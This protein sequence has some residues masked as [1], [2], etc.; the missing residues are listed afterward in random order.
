MLA[1]VA[2]IAG[3]FVVRQTAARWINDYTE[4]T[5]TQVEQVEYS[6]SQMDALNSRLAV[7]KQALDKGQTSVELV[8]TAEDLNALIAKEREWRGKLFVRID[9]DIVRGDVSIPLKDLG[10]FK[11]NGRYLNGTATF[12]LALAD[13][14][15]Q[16]RLREVQVR[17]KPLPAMVLAELKKENL[18]K[19][20]QQDP[21]A[22]ADFARFDS[23]QVTNG[24]V[25]LRNK[26]VAP[27]Q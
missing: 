1:I 24:Q 17:G 21:K 19:G 23:I 12:K 9:D 3:Y 13:G 18:A 22:A 16:V 14:V 6:K 10:P 7:F 25:V 2:G 8:L 5:P 15:L 27:G 20:F 11:L 4:A 26:V